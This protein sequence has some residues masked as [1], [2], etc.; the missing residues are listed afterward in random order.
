MVP[1][2]YVAFVTIEI[3]KQKHGGVI[4]PTWMCL[5]QRAGKKAPFTFVFFFFLKDWYKTL[6][7]SFFLVDSL[8]LVFGH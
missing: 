1:Y 6:G 3:G 4:S 7:T 2:I 8:T 5:H